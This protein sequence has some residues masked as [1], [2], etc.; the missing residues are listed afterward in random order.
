M[1][2]LKLDQLAP[3]YAAAEAFVQRCLRSD[4][5]LFPSGRP[6]WR[7]ACV[8]DLFRRFVE[9]PD[10]SSDD[11]MTKWQ[12][13]LDGAPADTVQFAAEL[14]YVHLLAGNT[15]GRQRKEELVREV[16]SWSER[17]TPIPEPLLEALERGFAGESTAWRTYRWA[18]LGY[19]VR[20]LRKFKALP[21]HERLPIRRQDRRGPGRQACPSWRGLLGAGLCECHSGR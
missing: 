20:F 19:L 10:M 15:T 18:L 21:G 5:S 13:Q 4:D 12:R 17:D 14:L 8:E 11:F 16:L 2:K 3:T 7:L 9:R 6:V 1:P